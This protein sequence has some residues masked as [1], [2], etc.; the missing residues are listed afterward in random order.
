[1][2]KELIDQIVSQLQNHE[3][4]YVPGAWERFQKKEEKK[5]GFIY[6]P[7][8]A[9]AVLVLVFSVVFFSTNKLDNNQAI[10]KNK[11]TTITDQK[12]E[13]IASVPNINE[14]KKGILPSE[15]NGNQPVVSKQN[16]SLNLEE[17]INEN[18]SLKANVS[19][20]I[21]N[22]EPTQLGSYVS[23]INLSSQK[24]KSFELAGLPKKTISPKTAFENLL[25]FDS[26]PAQQK[27]NLK[28][29]AESK[30]QP[31]VYVAPAMGNDN[32]VN[33]NY[34]FSLSYAIANNLSINSGVSYSAMSTKE[35]LNAG[36]PQTLSGKNLES[37]DAKVRG[38]N[39]PLELKYNISDKLYTGIGVSA[40]AVINNNQQNTYI[41]NQVQSMVVSD[42]SGMNV[43]KNYIV[44]EKTSETQPTSSLDLDKYIGFYN[45]SL[46]YKQKISP[47][48]KIAIEPFLRLPMKT[49]SKENLNLTNGG[50]RLKID[51]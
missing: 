30:W 18:P 44:S 34:G 26:Q 37:V 3:E 38:I 20:V 14:S 4:Q 36:A 33:M 46:G 45:F 50:L 35:T 15:A 23:N 29:E 32:K 39:I 31:G 43:A 24:G 8:W 47:K 16:T 1:M 10:S 2:D 5:R 9:A 51:F 17:V 27:N 19:T 25:A 11:K 13:V 41:E 40:L 48:K 21:I 12:Q 22:Q 28:R 49:F 42:P 6:W 7:L